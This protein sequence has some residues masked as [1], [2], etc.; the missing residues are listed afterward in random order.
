[1]KT[2]RPTTSS[3]RFYQVPDFSLLNK[4]RP[5]KSLITGAKKKTGGRSKGRISTRHIGGGAKQL[6]RQISFGQEKLGVPG[7]IIA[8]EYDPNRTA[9]IA[10]VSYKDGDWRYILA[11][12]GLTVGREIICK[13]DANFQQPGNRLILKNIPVGVFIHNIEIKPQAGGKIVK[14]AGTAAQ[15]LSQD[16]KYTFIKLPSKEVRK[17]LNICYASIGKLAGVSRQFLKLGKAGRSRLLGIRPT[18]RGKAMNPRDHPYGGGEG[19]TKRGLKKPKT[20]WGKI[21][22]GRKTRKKNKY[23]NKFIVK[24]RKQ[25]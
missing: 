8:I 14:G 12:E 3:R 18:V 7:K 6:Y 11:P 17:F 15:I 16:E 19:R 9:F 25:K 21:T 24:R 1:M 4:K 5:F 13:E 22:G 23:S 10:L 20:K 2:V